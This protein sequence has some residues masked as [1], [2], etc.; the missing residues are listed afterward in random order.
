MVEKRWKNKRQMHRYWCMLG[1]NDHDYDGHHHEHCCAV[2]SDLCS[3]HRSPTTSSSA[4]HCLQREVKNSFVNLIWQINIQSHFIANSHSNHSHLYRIFTINMN[5][6]VLYIDLSF[7]HHQFAHQR[8]DRWP[9]NKTAF[10]KTQEKSFCLNLQEIKYSAHY[11]YSSMF[12]WSWV[13]NKNKHLSNESE[14]FKNTAEA[15]CDEETA[16]VG[17]KTRKSSLSHLL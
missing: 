11:F 15:R 13:K 1:D 7:P 16:L 9:C 5:V 3:P 4:L 17:I 8:N 6:A 14:A 12:N 10:T 2:S